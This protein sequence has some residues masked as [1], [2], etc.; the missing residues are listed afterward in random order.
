[1]KK[2]VLR[3]Y[4]KI[5]LGLDVTGTR[6]D[7]YHL[8]K[9]IMQTVGLYDRLEFSVIEAEKPEIICNKAF[10]PVNENNLIYKAIELVRNR[11]KIKETL[12]VSLNKR[13]P[14]AAGMAG[15]SSDAAVTLKAMNVLFSL[16]MSDEEL[17]ELGLKLG[18]DVP[19]CLLGGTVLAEGIGEV[20]TPINNA[21]Q[22]KVLLVK[23]PVNI[24]TPAVYRALDSE[25]CYAHPEIN[26]IQSAI[27]DDDLVGMC[28]AMGNVLETVSIKNYPII[29]AIKEQMLGLGAVGAMMSGSGPTVFGLFDDEE[30]AKKAYGEFR[31]GKLGKGTFLTEFY[32]PKGDKGV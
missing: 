12:R 13:I 7:G 22:C 21:P 25:D 17:A 32:F 20:L 4:G 24:S 15:G 30:K 27:A 8:V 9:M 19:Y 3:A 6:E 18:A 14:V 29:T 1:M 10:L 2:C 31:K 16:G 28:N 5:N 11:Y 23:P 26:V